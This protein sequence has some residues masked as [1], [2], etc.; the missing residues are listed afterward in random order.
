M[1]LE[2][3]AS[4]ARRSTGTSSISGATVNTARVAGLDEGHLLSVKRTLDKNMLE[5]NRQGYLNGHTPFSALVA[6]SSLIAAKLLNLSYGPVQRIQR[7][8]EHG[9][10]EHGEPP[11]LQELSV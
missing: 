7:Q 3:A 6:F 5:L 1:T 8:R 2:L 11:V 10:R 9:P 4:P